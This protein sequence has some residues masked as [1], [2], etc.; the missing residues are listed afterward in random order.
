MG[1]QLRW[2]RQEMRHERARSSHQG[3]TETPRPDAA[4]A[5][6]D[7]VTDMEELLRDVAS[8][9]VELDDERLRYV[10]VQIDR[11]TWEALIRWRDERA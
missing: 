6:I 3:I 11:Q 4:K 2:C 7:Q 10:V 5:R 9:G 8:S 1:Q